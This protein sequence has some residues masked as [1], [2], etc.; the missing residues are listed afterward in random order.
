MAERALEYVPEPEQPPTRVV[1]LLPGIITD[2]DVAMVT[3]YDTKNLDPG[4]LDNPALAQ[5]AG[6]SDNSSGIWD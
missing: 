1:S 6:E 5:T 4:V 2:K 3:D